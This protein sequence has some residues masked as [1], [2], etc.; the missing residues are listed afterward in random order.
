[1]TSNKVVYDEKLRKMEEDFEQ[2]CELKIK[3]RVQEVEN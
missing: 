3:K 1:M 2:K